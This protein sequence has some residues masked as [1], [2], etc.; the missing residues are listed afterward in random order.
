MFLFPWAADKILVLVIKRWERSLSSVLE[1]SKL[2]P[3]CLELM[4][5]VLKRPPS[6]MHPVLTFLA[7]KLAVTWCVCATAVLVVRL[8]LLQLAVREVVLM[9]SVLTGR[10]N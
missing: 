2:R 9:P 10:D 1:A 6:P 3:G 4:S 8:I 5:I 7:C